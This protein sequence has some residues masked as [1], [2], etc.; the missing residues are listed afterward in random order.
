MPLLNTVILGVRSVEL[1][2]KEDFNLDYASLSEGLSKIND[3]YNNKDYVLFA[4][5]LEYL[6]LPWFKALIDTIVPRA[7]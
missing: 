4:D 5:S 3:A 7:K 1:S 6:L 2:L